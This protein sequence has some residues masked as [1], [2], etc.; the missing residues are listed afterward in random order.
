MK[1]I[2]QHTVVKLCS[3]RSFLLLQ[4]NSSTQRCYCSAAITSRPLPIFCWRL[5]KI[6][7]FFVLSL[8]KLVRIVIMKEISEMCI[9]R[10]GEK[11]QNNSSSSFL[12]FF[13]IYFYSWLFR[14]VF[15][16]ILNNARKPMSI[17]H[18]EK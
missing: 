18:F 6:S 2:E 7:I 4:L 10:N 3:L 14:S 16:S 13:F 1:L 15:F 5:I 9:F 12:A 11:K 8:F 17:K